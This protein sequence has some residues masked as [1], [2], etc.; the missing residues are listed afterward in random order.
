[1]KRS[2]INKHSRRRKKHLEEWNRVRV[3]VLWRDKWWCQYQYKNCLGAATQVSHVYTKGAYPFLEFDM[4]NLVSTCSHCHQYY[5][6]TTN[7]PKKF[8]EDNHPL[9]WER[10]QEK[11]HDWHR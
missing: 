5:E 9:R 1:M 3:R 10:I 7:E 11:I 6:G 2:W 4:D 8:L